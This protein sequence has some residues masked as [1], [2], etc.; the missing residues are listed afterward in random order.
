MGD[1]NVSGG[2]GT[3]GVTVPAGC[4]W[5]AVSN[6][7]WVTIT[8]GAAGSGS[9]SVTYAV[10]PMTGTNSRTAALTIANQS[11]AIDQIS[12][13]LINSAAT[14][15]KNLIAAGINFDSGA[16]ILTRKRV[17]TTARTRPH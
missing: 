10:T 16:V 17:C 3:V 11:F 6:S 9:G 5:T 15:G 12:G 7:S 8:S 14:E 1:T 4:N 2:T 13:P